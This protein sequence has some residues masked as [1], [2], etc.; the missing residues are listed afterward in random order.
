MSDSEL[1][2]APTREVPS[3]GIL[4]K[5]LRKETAEQ[6]EDE[7]KTINTIRRGAELALDLDEGFFANDG[8][9]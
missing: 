8:E 1:S 9:W 6:F 3:D 5:T 7:G 4:E 2:D